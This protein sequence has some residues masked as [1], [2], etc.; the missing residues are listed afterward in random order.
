MVAAAVAIVQGVAK[1]RVCFNTWRLGNLAIAVVVSTIWPW[2]KA[3]LYHLICC[4]SCTIYFTDKMIILSHSLPLF[5]FLQMATAKELITQDL[6]SPLSHSENCVAVRS[7]FLLK[8]FFCMDLQ[9]VATAQERVTVGCPTAE[10]LFQNHC[11]SCS[12]HCLLM[13]Y[14]Y[15]CFLLFQLF[16]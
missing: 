16:L 10:F 5:V 7:L 6:K 1:G 4:F 14:L 9:S 13:A 3:S 2:P 11:L 12:T 8:T 15:C